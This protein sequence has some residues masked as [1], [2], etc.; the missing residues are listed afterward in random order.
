MELP[1][2]VRRARAREQLQVVGAEWSGWSRP[3]PSES[4]RREV[5]IPFRWLGLSGRDRT[6]LLR[7]VGALAVG[8]DELHTHVPVGRF[9]VVDDSELDSFTRKQIEDLWPRRIDAMLRFGRAWWIVECKPDANHYVLG[10]VLCYAY[11]LHR[12]CP[13]VECTRVI[14]A[15]DRCDPEVKPVLELCGVSVVELRK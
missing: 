2:P 1:K 12:D 10:Q 8:P 11:W 5:G 14:V 9:P 7:F 4:T 3:G 13:W 15:T 6:L